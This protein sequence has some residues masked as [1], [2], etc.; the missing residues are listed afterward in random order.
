MRPTVLFLFN[1][2]EYAM[3][4]WLRNGD[5][6]VV[7]VDYSDTD[8][9]GHHLMQTHGHGFL[10]FNID[11]SREDAKEAVDA[12]GPIF[13]RSGIGLIFIRFRECLVYEVLGWILFE[14]FFGFI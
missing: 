14:V 1:H 6:N 11:L 12:K 10:R 5:F 2:S 4:P 3:L 13:G 9:S 8:H 7:T